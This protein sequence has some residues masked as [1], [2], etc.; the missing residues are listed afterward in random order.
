MACIE[1]VVVCSTNSYAPL[2]SVYLFTFLFLQC[3]IVAIWRVCHFTQPVSAE[4]CVL[5]LLNTT[6]Q[7]VNRPILG[8]S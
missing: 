3:L 5:S 6:Y 4:L 8:K 2:L 1:E 7:P